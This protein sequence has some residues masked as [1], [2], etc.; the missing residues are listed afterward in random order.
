ML[1]QQVPF[2]LAQTITHPFDIR[3]NL[4]FFCPA[5]S[6]CSQPRYAA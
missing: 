6:F 5:L 2:E 4:A 1:L 3:S